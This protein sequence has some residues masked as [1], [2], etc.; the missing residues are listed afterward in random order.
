MQ[1]LAHIFGVGRIL[2]ESASNSRF[3]RVWRARRDRRFESAARRTAMGR[4]GKLFLALAALGGTSLWLVASTMVSTASAQPN[5]AQLPKSDGYLL[6]WDQ[7]EEVDF[8]NSATGHVG[9]LIPPY[10]PNGQLCLFPNPSGR[11]VTAYN[12][13]LASQNN[14]GSLKPIMQ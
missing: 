5:R 8:F 6:Y 12:P 11:F 14:P 7:N 9:Q 2:G 4:W 10:N 3:Q 1:R 13:T